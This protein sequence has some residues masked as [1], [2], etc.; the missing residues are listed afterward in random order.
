MLIATA[1][2]RPASPHN[3]AARPAVFQARSKSSGRP[4]PSHAA[5][6]AAPA[7]RTATERT[8]T[9]RTATER[10]GVAPCREMPGGSP[11]AGNRLEKRGF[12]ELNEAL[13]SEALQASAPLLERLRAE[14]RQRGYA[15][16]TEENYAEWVRRYVLFNA[17]QGRQE[18]SAQGTH[19]FLAHL[20]CDVR[21]AASTLGQVRNALLFLHC[22]VLGGDIREMNDTA[23]AK[24]PP[25]RPVVLSRQEVEKIIG[26]MRGTHRLMAE[27]IYA[28][29]LT[30]MECVRLRVRDVDLETGYVVVRSE[31]GD[32]ERRV[33]LPHDV[34]ESLRLH[35]DTVRRL[36]EQDK[37][38]GYGR[39]PL[40]PHIVSSQQAHSD[41]G[42]EFSPELEWGWQYA[43]PSSRLSAVHWS[44]DVHRH[45]LSQNGLQKAVQ[46]AARRQG[47]R[48]VSVVSRCAIASPRICCKTAT[49]RAPCNVGWDT[50]TPA[51]PFYN[52]FYNR[53]RNEP[54][55]TGRI[56][57]VA[58]GNRN[59]H[60]HHWR[61]S[62]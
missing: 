4:S 39:A 41:S 25:R 50:A 22:H 10:T 53:F 16:G 54:R 59:I 52:R 18:V 49:T 46:A 30:L 20:A 57:P 55:S 11:L 56:K 26:G 29:G 48:A 58:V 42:A 40:P 9:E 43:F 44:K 60:R 32:K 47:T 35:L 7:E 34:Q 6:D 5:P 51:R 17:E 31:S 62:R 8:A 38:E 14:M 61:S 12:T 37:A 24:R 45:H 36:H 15:P 13:G 23:W 3:A 27:L 21:V 33:P 19:S 2:T 1:L 28:T